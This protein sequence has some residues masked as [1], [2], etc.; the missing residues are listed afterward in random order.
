MIGDGVQDY[1]S[2]PSIVLQPDHAFARQQTI[3]FRT[4]SRHLGVSYHTAYELV[5]VSQVK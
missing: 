4:R 3:P 1:S 2:L 5:M